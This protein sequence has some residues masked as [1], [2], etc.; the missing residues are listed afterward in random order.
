M[1]IGNFVEAFEKLQCPRG[2][3]VWGA[4]FPGWPKVADLSLTEGFQQNRRGAPAKLRQGC[5]CRAGQWEGI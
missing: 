4:Q 1:G 2:N 3:E 5:T